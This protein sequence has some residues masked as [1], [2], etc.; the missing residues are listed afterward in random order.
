MARGFRI[1]SR[2]LG[3]WLR[4][5]IVAADTLPPAFDEHDMPA[6]FPELPQLFPHAEPATVRNALV[7][8]TRAGVLKQIGGKGSPFC[9][10]APEPGDGLAAI[11]E[12]LAA[13]AKAEQVLRAQRNAVAKLA[14][15]RRL[16]AA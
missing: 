5:R 8:L 3:D 12:A 10:A 13:L 14:E 16:V 1:L 2:G 15:L 4:A 6:L 7:K 11:D 9:Y